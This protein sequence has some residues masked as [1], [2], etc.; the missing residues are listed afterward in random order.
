MLER[1]NSNEDLKKIP[2]NRLGD[3]A[4]EI[5][6]FLID[7]ISRTGGHLASNLGV[8]ELTIALHRVYD[9]P[10]DRI[11]WDVGHQAYTHKILSGRRDRFDTLRKKDGLSGFPRRE[12]S[13]YDCFDTGHSSTSISAA[14]GFVKARELTGEDYNVCAVIGDGSFTGGEVFEAMNNASSLDTNMVVVLNDNAMSISRNVGGI[15]EYL[16]KVRTSEA[17]TGL[18]MGVSSTLSKMPVLGDNLVSAIRKT[19]TGI[20]HFIIPGMFF[21]DMGFTYLG[22][23]DGHDIKQLIRVITEAKKVKGPVIVHAI[24]EKGHG[25]LPAQKDPQ[26]FHG[27]PSFTA[28]SGEPLK[29]KNET[30]TDVFS[31][32]IVK[33]AAENKK[34]VAVTA[35]MAEGTGL[36]RFAS[37]YP[38]RFIDVGI[39]EAHAVTYCASLAISG[40]VPVFAVYSSFL[41]RGYDQVMMDVCAQKLHVVFAIDRGGFV[42]ADG[43][44]HQGCFDLS[45]LS[46]I[47]G[48]TVMAPKNAAE[49]RMMLDFAVNEMTGPVAVRYPRGEA[50]D[51]YESFSAPIE[52][53]KWEILE[54]G[55]KVALVAAGAAVNTAREAAEIL[56]NEGYG[57]SV[58]NARFIKP[59]DEEMLNELAQDHDYI[60]TMEENVRCGGL[61][62]Q[63]LDTAN[64]N[65]L[66]AGI[67]ISAIP[68]MFVRH[69]SIDQQREVTCTNAGSIVKL[70][71]ETERADGCC[72]K[73]K[74]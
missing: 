38:D 59:V 70:F 8:V 71:H 62:A 3:L 5:R 47:P 54:K 29:K 60:I 50:L 65:G 25:Y 64:A 26:R 68:D 33:I 6:A 23:V 7:S 74:T 11:V 44:T 45:Y 20:K 39:A 22:P 57:P 41:Q 46:M 10:K 48:M 49:L 51:C 31:S 17:Y 14:L 18:K 42:G 53:G 32:E 36:R 37:L 40:L 13:D 9:L 55:S 27:T 67:I 63:V 61:G 24:T 15:S 66:K 21:E 43:K 35:A 12:E 34:V 19:K 30:Y 72:S 56:R 73:G 2:E 28:S 52:Y 1:I 16:A 69:G 58:V 4:S